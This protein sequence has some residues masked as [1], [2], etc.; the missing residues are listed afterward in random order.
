MQQKH[1]KDELQL[2]GQ[3]GNHD[4]STQ[5]QDIEPGTKPRNRNMQLPEEGRLPSTRKCT[6]KNIIYEAKISTAQD[7]KHYIGLTA[8]TFKAHHAGHKSTFK[9][10]EKKHSTEL[11]KYIWKLK[12]E[13]APYTITW[14]VIRHAQP[15]FPRTKRCKLCLWEKYFIITA[16]KDNIL[17]SRTELISTCRHKKKFLLSG[18]G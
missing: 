4:K 5:Q 11:S 6:T 2:H 10:K 8:T 9:D 12:D 16:N 15:Y 7:E 14:R 13:G 18:Y 1:L 17:N 3:H